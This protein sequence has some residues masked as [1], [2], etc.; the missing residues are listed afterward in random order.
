MSQFRPVGRMGQA[1]PADTRFRRVVS[2][3]PPAPKAPD[4]TGRCK[5]NGDTC[6]AYAVKGGVLCVGHQRALDK[7]TDEEEV[8][9]EEG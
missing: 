4:R 1:K 2:G 6:K 5:A 3:P 7:V 9:D 8:V